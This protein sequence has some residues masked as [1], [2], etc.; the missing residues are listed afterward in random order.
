M[1]KTHKERFARSEQYYPHIASKFRKF[2]CYSVPIEPGTKK[3]LMKGWTKPMADEEFEKSCKIYLKHGTGLLLGKVN[4]LVAIDLDL[5]EKDP[6]QSEILKTII[7]II[8]DAQVERFGSKG[9]VRIYTY[10]GE[11]NY[12]KTFEFYDYYNKII[13][14]LK[15]IELHSSGR[16]VVMPPSEHPSGSEYRYTK[17]SI[18][19]F[20]DKKNFSAIRSDFL[21]QYEEA[22]AKLQKDFLLHQDDSS[23]PVADELSAVFEKHL[24][25]EVST[26]KMSKDIG[27]NDKLKSIAVASIKNGNSE[28]QVANEL[29]AYDSKHHTVPLFSDKSEGFGGDALISATKFTKSVLL[30]IEPDPSDYFLTLGELRESEKFSHVQ[31]IVDELLTTPGV[32][33]LAGKPKIGK[34]TLLLDL[35]RKISKGESVLER[36]TQKSKVLFISLENSL[37]HLKEYLTEKIDITC[38]SRILISHRPLHMNDAELIIK[39]CKKK[40]IGFVVIDTLGKFL[41][42]SDFNDYAKVINEMDKL[43]QLA[44][45]ANVHILTTHHTVKSES[46]GISS[47]MGST[48]FTG[49]V[50][51]IIHYDGSISQTVRSI[52]SQQ[53]YGKSINLQLDYDK[54]TKEYSPLFGEEADIK[55]KTIKAILQKISESEKPLKRDQIRVGFKNQAVTDAL[56]TLV[57]KEKIVMS[58]S[59]KKN[60]PTVFSV[61]LGKH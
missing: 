6:L 37:N 43:T 27:R 34:T 45:E 5:D 13:V 35:I 10:S 15:P 54:T 50:D 61:P 60:D 7:S 56:K 59:G 55:A 44:T 12:N 16:Q 36:S 17:G 53:R 20:A 8:P 58:G 42:S 57:E 23:K 4:N 39:I 26:T 33:I 32:S 29:V 52:E 19:S 25:K 11:K 2:G 30:S 41:Q 49:S 9:F 51:T 46:R 24:T 31:Y 22:I 40:D 21:E 47:V 14:N 18:E 38:D 48:A 3:C 1:P 28:A